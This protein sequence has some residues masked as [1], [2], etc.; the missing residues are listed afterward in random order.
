MTPKHE[1]T[2]GSETPRLFM[3]PGL[4]LEMIE[5]LVQ[6]TLEEEVER[7]LGAGYYERS[8][9]RRGRRNGTKPRSMKT[10]LG[11]LQLELP[12]VREGGFRTQ[13]FER[14]QRSDKA[15]VAAMQEMVVQGVSTRDVSAVMEELGGFEVSA[16]TVSRAMAELDEQIG[17]FFSRKLTECE[18]PYLIIDARYEKVRKNGRVV[19]QAV[20]VAAGIRDDGR[21]ELLSLR[22]GDS[23]SLAT[24]GELFSDLKARGIGGVE[25][26]VSDAH[27][28]IIAAIGKHFQGVAWQRCKVHLM[29]EMLS[30]VSWKDWRE[31]ARDLRSI[32]TSEET[33]QCLLVAEEVAAKWEKRAPAMSRA[34][35]AGVEATLTVKGLLDPVTQRRLNSTNMLERTMKEIKKRT[36]KVGSFPN[37]DSCRR[38]VG[39]ILLE[40]Q[41]KWDGEQTRYVVVRKERN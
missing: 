39:A 26:I 17:A 22:L 27:G 33:S 23:E 32:Y 36:R 12:Q 30:K 38:L 2:K 20:L 35:E 3:E 4:L 34:L 14:Y 6:R 25:L 15:L 11:E 1:T 31:L 18:Y 37:G 5:T 13:V 10:A 28:G 24:W 41:D 21:R 40:M 9:D 7:Y 8:A 29:R 19:S 16:A